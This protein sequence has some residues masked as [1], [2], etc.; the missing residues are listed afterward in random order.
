MSVESFIRALPKA[1]LGLQFEGSIPHK[2]L[3][4]VADHNDKKSEK[5]YLSVERQLKEPDLNKLP[6][7]ILALSQWVEFADN[8]T[9]L[10]YEI[11]VSLAKQNIRYAEISVNPL[12]YTQNNMSFDKFI[13]AMHDGADRV[14]RGWKVRLSWILT[15]P[16]EDP[17]RTDEIARWSMSVTGKKNGVVAIGLAG[18][19]ESQSAA[20]YERPFRNVEKKDF[21]R[22]IHAGDTKGAEG[23]ADV[24]QHINPT[25]IL[26][27]WGAT[28]AEGIMQR[29]AEARIPLILYITRDVRMT[30]A[31]S[32]TDYPLR[33]LLDAGVP[34]TLSAGMPELYKTSTANEYLHMVDAG[35]LTVDEVVELTLNS[36]RHALLPADEKAALLAEFSAEIESL[37]EQ[38]LD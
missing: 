32:Y 23:I 24:L 27:G 29:L 4:L 3:L 25:R 19:E 14:Y 16:R 8:L 11:G 7:L 38:H 5:G 30:R 15:V 28:N 10:T 18:R 33:P 22:V 12:L 6:E 1:E 37:R 36:V 2:G 9:R 17:R 26:G 35:V 31:A 34:V 13:E 20:P 21:P